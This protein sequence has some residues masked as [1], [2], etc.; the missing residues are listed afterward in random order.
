MNAD[1]RAAAHQRRAKIVC[2]IGPATRSLAQL[3]LLVEAGMDVARLNLSHGVHGDHAAVIA[4]LRQIAAE[5]DRP[6]AIL[7]DLQGPK[8]RI[9]RLAG[10]GRVE[11]GAGASLTITT[12]EVPGDES[13]VSTD[14]ARLPQEVGAGDELL[15]SDGLI[16]LVV[17]AV[18]GPDVTCEVVNAGTLR[19]RAGMNLPGV[20]LDTPSLTLKDRDDLQ[21]GMEQGVDYVALSFVRRPEDLHELRGLMESA[22]AACGIVAKLEKPQ[23]IARLDAILEAADAVMIARGD[24]GVELSPERVPFVQKQVIARAA[25]LKVPVITATQMLESMIDHPQ[26]TRAEASDIANAV[27]D[28]TDAVMLSGET[29][30]G[31][32]PLEA[33]RMMHRIVSE[34]E[35]SSVDG[36]LPGPVRARRSQDPPAGFTDALAEAACRLALQVKA[37]AIVTFTRAGYTARLISKGRPQTPIIAFTASE[38]V[39]R[40]LS[41]YWG[42]R[43]RR[44]E[45]DTD[46]DRMIRTANQA[47]L[48]DGALSP[49]DTVVVVA[50]SPSPGL[51]GATNWLELHRIGHPS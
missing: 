1:L 50:G 29:A 36:G 41:L 18:D 5:V 26:P 27:L 33:V 38:T 10:G 4:A 12:R 32:Y 35:A 3:R 28:G 15:L 6:I 49:G 24:L 14:Y 43:S 9:G 44:C 31:L 45:F 8:I 16:R 19:E 34:A 17:R 25:R 20:E 22:G 47:L 40:R 7:L 13:C 46:V 42:V 21:F 2:T 11:L 51:R 37:S 48:D 30:I 23:A 39:C